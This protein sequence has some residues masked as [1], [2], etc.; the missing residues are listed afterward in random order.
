MS[1]SDTRTTM[2]GF[3]KS[4]Y[5]TEKSTMDPVTE[6]VAGKAN[7]KKDVLNSLLH[8]VDTRGPELN[9]KASDFAVKLQTTI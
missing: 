8:V 3:K 1:W 9:F 2:L 7:N 6:G 5:E 4:Q